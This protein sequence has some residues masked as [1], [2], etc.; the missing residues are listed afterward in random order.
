M[1]ERN[2]GLDRKPV[3]GHRAGTR[4]SGASHGA[5][6]LQPRRLLA[7]DRGEHQV[8]GRASRRGHHEGQAIVLAIAAGRR[9]APGRQRPSGR[10]WSPALTP[11]EREVAALISDG[12]TNREIE[13]NWP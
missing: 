3:A 11:P 12:L 13:G 8:P 10:G 9:S 2:F 5:G 7:R 4:Q 6:R 1:S